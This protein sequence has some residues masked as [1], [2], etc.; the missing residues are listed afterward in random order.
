MVTIIFEPHATTTD[1]EAGLASGWND[2]ALSEAGRRQA[3]ELG[4]RRQLND[5]DAIFTPDLERAYRTIRLA[6]PD[7]GPRQLHIDWRLRE[8]D[9]G[10]LTQHPKEE[11][12]AEKPQRITKPFPGGES[13]DQTA[14]RMRSF[15]QDLLW[16]HDGQ[17]VLVIG[18]RATQYGLD[19]WINS[20]PLEQA[21]TAPWK[22]QPG[23]T[24]ELK[25]I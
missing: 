22:W 20:I 1:N 10:Q 5:F 16:F 14:A 7:I 6:F 8:C 24:Y 19:H 13:Y 21:V 25:T 15:L 2:V 23:W 3:E 9:Y 4:K 11:V 12:D 18:H 17:T